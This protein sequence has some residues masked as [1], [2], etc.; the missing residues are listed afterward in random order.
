VEIIGTAIDV[1]PD[2]LIV[3]HDAKT[4]FRLGR[5]WLTATTKYKDGNIRTAYLRLAQIDAAH[6]DYRHERGRARDDAHPVLVF[7][8]GQTAIGI[9]VP[10]AEKAA[11]AF[12]E[13]V[14]VVAAATV[15]SVGK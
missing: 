14:F 6:V 8:A 15:K 12:V 1:L 9:A 7:Q 13:R 2:E 4:T 3:L 10:S 5:L 11:R